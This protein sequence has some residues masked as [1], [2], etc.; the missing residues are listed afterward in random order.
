MREPG[1]REHTK[2]VRDKKKDCQRAPQINEISYQHIHL[3]HIP[4]RVFIKEE[5]KK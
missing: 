2:A 5:E 4:N 3:S 1:V